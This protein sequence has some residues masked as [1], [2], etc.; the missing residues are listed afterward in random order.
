[1]S[2]LH[3][4]EQRSRVKE[5]SDI[6]T[7]DIFELVYWLIDHVR[8]IVIA[9]VVGALVMALYS[10]VL[11]KPV[12]SAT[13]SI[14]VLSSSDSA[15]NLSDLQIGS[16]LTSDYQHVFEVWEVHEMVLQRLG[17]DYTYDELHDMLEITNPTNTRVLNITVSSP[18]PQE[19]ADMANAYAAV[20]S[21]YISATMK[22]DAP[23]LMSP[24]LLPE[25]PVSPRKKLNT[26]FGA[27]GG[28]FLTILI[29]MVQYLLDDKLKT[30][31]DITKYLELPVLSVLPLNA[32]ETVKNRRTGAKQTLNEKRDA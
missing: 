16:Y 17:L 5:P 26:L 27:A 30:A 23:T 2:Q 11:A 8:Q 15:I 31:D 10:F 1:M 18:D 3:P 21:D 7:I 20:A 22:T 13:S 12:Y 32:D 24:A 14:Y 9:T 4:S 29:L 6:A 25:K 28:A 19:A